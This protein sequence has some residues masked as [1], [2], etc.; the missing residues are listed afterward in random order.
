MFF[1]RQ[2]R[3]TLCQTSSRCLSRGLL[4]TCWLGTMTSDSTSRLQNTAAACWKRA[5][6]IWRFL[7][8]LSKTTTSTLTKW[9]VSLY[10]LMYFQEDIELICQTNLRHMDSV[11]KMSVH[12]DTTAF[13]ELR[14]QWS[15]LLSSVTNP[16]TK[17]LR[18]VPVFCSVAYSTV[19]DRPIQ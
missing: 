3:T 11:I 13:R 8:S 9:L 5:V 7:K 10:D 17:M 16:A 19:S 14:Q 12:S 4:K 18:T 1:S 6:L 15:R 2:R